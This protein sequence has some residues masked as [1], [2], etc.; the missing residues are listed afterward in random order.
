[1]PFSLLVAWRYI[2]A[3]TMQ[4]LLL[5]I[6]VALSVIVFVFITALINGLNIL[7]TEETTSKIAHVKLEPPNSI[8][9]ILTEDARFVAQPISILQ[10][11]QIRNWQQVIDIVESTPGVRVVSP[12]VDSSAFLVR[13]EAVR[14]IAIQGVEPNKID[15]ISSISTYLIEGSADLSTGGLMMGAELAADLGLRVGTPVL[16]RS[17]RGAERL[18]PVTGIFKVGLA[19]LDQ[20]V[21]FLS[22]RSARPLFALPDGVTSLGIKLP[23]ALLKAAI[24][25]SSRSPL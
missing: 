8:A 11:K 18:L 24:C 3:N 5:V 16:L 22:I 6:G 10:R 12:T 7:L 21:A 9:R 1:M 20:R 2:T 4:T 14:P 19:S 15:A 17:E 25:L 13:G 23:I